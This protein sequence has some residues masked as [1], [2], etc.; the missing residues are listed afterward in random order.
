MGD[1]FHPPPPR[2]VRETM[3]PVIDEIIQ[4]EAEKTAPPSNLQLEK[5]VWPGER[6]HP[7]ECHGSE[8]VDCD[9][10]ETHCE[11]G[12]RVFGLVSAIRAAG[13]YGPP[14]PR[15]SHNKDGGGQC[16]Y[17]WE[18]AYIYHEFVIKREAVRGH[19]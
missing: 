4:H 3:L 18:M 16:G 12:N 10:A 14:F 19:Q 13:F 11:G 15:H 5:S 6:H 8:C 2:A 9:I 17:R 7:C 1:V